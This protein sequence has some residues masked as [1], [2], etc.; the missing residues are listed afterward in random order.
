MVDFDARVAEQRRALEVA[1]RETQ[2][3]VRRTVGT[4]VRKRAWLLPLLAAGLGLSLSLALRR[5]RRNTRRA[6][7][8]LRGRGLT[9]P[10]A[11]T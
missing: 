8:A 10:L 3:G 6:P 2:D 11:S 4:R 5:A 7:D 1:L 9:R